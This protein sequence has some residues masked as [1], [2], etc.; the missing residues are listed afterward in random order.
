[1]KAIA[2]PILIATGLMLAGNNEASPVVQ[3]NALVTSSG[4][5]I[6]LTSGVA[7]ITGA[8]ESDLMK[9]AVAEA[10]GRLHGVNTVRNLLDVNHGKPNPS[11]GGHRTRTSE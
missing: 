2:P 6:D 10:A 4:I 5:D 7:T 8:V 3:N 9:L 1:M 11:P